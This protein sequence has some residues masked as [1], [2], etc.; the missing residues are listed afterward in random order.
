MFSQIF[1]L[2]RNTFECFAM[3]RAQFSTYFSVKSSCVLL[4][5]EEM[6]ISPRARNFSQ[7]FFFKSTLSVLRCTSHCVRLKHY[8]SVDFTWGQKKY[9]DTFFH[10]ADFSNPKTCEMTK[11]QNCNLRFDEKSASVKICQWTEILGILESIWKSN[12]WMDPLEKKNLLYQFL[13]YCLQVNLFSPWIAFL[14]KISMNQN[15][16]A[17]SKS[18]LVKIVSN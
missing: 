10:L 7:C 12:A 11:I 18:Q 8:Y 13:F 15:F 14:L 9:S 5:R 1:W 16:F 6:V 17:K 3:F 2:H 4:T